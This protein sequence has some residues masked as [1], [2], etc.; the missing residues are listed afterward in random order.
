MTKAQKVMKGLECCTT[1]DE[2]FDL[3]KKCPYRSQ[4]GQPNKCHDLNRDALELIKGLLQWTSR[5][6]GGV[7]FSNGFHKWLE[8]EMREKNMDVRKM[9]NESGLSVVAI[10][11]FLRGDR[12]PTLQSFLLILEALGKELTIVDKG[13]SK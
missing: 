1:D 8:D 12:F 4:D 7:T 2:R 11:Y 3:C 5:Y 9:S 10:R 6:V 13:G